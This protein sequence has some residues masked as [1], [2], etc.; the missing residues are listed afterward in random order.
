M[1]RISENVIVK[2]CF[3][4][5]FIV[6]ERWDF[7]SP[8][9]FGHCRCLFLIL[10][11]SDSAFS[12]LV[13]EI[14][15]RVL[16]L[17]KVLQVSLNLSFKSIKWVN[18]SFLCIIVADYRALLLVSLFHENLNFAQIVFQPAWWWLFQ[19][20]SHEFQGTSFK[21]IVKLNKWRNTK[22]GEVGSEIRKLKLIDV[23]IRLLTNSV[24]MICQFW[25]SLSK[26]GFYIKL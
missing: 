1:G 15:I 19:V 11:W 3:S 7:F 8:V 5:I 17:L 6:K 18:G 9:I 25:A 21:F 13:G 23:E 26:W 12:V 16:I 10:R 22:L 2:V 24:P 20:N 14:R 4:N